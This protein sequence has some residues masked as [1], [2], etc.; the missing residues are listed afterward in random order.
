MF[1]TNS[2]IKEENKIIII[3]YCNLEL[4]LRVGYAFKYNKLETV[5]IGRLIC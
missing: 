5:N 1:L 3:I 4:R 2:D